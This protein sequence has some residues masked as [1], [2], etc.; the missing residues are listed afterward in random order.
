MSV[1]L[2]PI[3][4]GSVNWG[5]TVNDYWDQ[6]TD[7]FD[8]TRAIDALNI[9]IG[10]ASNV[11][12]KIKGAASQTGDLLQLLDNSSNIK[13]HADENGQLFIHA[14][15]SEPADGVFNNSQWTLWLDETSDEFELKAKKANGTTIT[16]TVGSSSA[17]HDYIL[18]IDQKDY[19]VGGGTFTAGSW[20]T[21]DLTDIITDTGGNASLSANEITLAEGTYECYIRCPAFNVRRHIARLQ[22][23]NGG[24]S[25][26]I[27]GS[28][29]HSVSYG[30]TESVIVGRF[31]V[32]E[33][34][35]FKVQ[36][37]GQQTQ[38]TTGFGI[39]NNFTDVDN[40]YTIA[41]FIKV[42]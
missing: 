7:A 35:K 31:T 12:L 29:E 9:E 10:S 25:V 13:T 41:K 17:T 40:T 34:D 3:T 16:Q 39:N 14:P 33:N 23:T 38:S 8:G 5:G 32:A 20:Q 1:T 37:M 22:K 27:L 26:V 11:G 15:A 42:A 24:G 36:H 21:R 30:Q 2:N 6:I 19:N 28:S 4:V 18:I